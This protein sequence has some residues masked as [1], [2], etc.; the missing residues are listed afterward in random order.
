MTKT[1]YQVGDVVYHWKHG[2]GTIVEIKGEHSFPIKVQFKEGFS[3]F[4][5]DGAES[6]ID[7]MPTLSFTPYDFIKGG[8]SNQRPIRQGTVIYIKDFKGWRVRIFSHFDYTGKLY[9]FENGRFE[10]CTLPCESQWS[11]KNPMEK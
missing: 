4:T 8:F 3:T 2:Q 1:N 6:H 5:L 7:G 11:L 9:Y 10:G